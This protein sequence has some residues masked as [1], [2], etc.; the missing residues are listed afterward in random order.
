MF[1][2]EPNWKE[3]IETQIP[4]FQIANNPE[5]VTV[6]GLLIGLRWTRT[7]SGIRI[8]G[9]VSSRTYGRS[10][11]QVTIIAQNGAAKATRTFSFTGIS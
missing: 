1:L 7:S 8:H 9:T 5:L 11:G 10:T 2:S 6:R 3:L 4:Q